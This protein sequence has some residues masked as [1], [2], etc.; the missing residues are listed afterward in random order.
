MNPILPKEYYIPDVEAR[1]WDDGKVYLYGSNDICGADFYCSPI[2]RVFS[3]GDM[4]EW[5]A[6]EV[7]F[8]GY[9]K[10]DNRAVVPGILYAPD[11]ICIDGEYCLFYC[12]ENGGEGMAVS[13]SPT[14]PFTG[15]RVLEYADMTQIDPAVFQDE[16]GT[17]YYYWGQ[18]SAQAG[19]LNKE[20]TGLV[21]ESIV[22]GILTEEE[23]GFHEGISVRK[24][25]GIY[26]VIYTDISRG[27]ATC[28]GYATGTSPLGPFK[29]QGII[30]DNTGCD[31]STWNNHGSIAE[32]DGRWYV[33]YHRST[34]NSRFSRRVCI[35]PIDFDANGRIKE[36]EMTTQGA[37]EPMDT[38]QSM[39][40]SNACLLWGK[41]Y[42]D[43]DENKNEFLG[44]MEDGDW[45]CYK[46][47]DFQGDENEIIMEAA[48]RGLSEVR[49]YADTVHGECIGRIMFDSD[50][51]GQRV[52]VKGL[53]QKNV[54]GIHALYMEFKGEGEDFLH[55]WNFKFN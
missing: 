42:I 51:V 41:V 2:Y 14:G 23:H 8:T 30:I 15:S 29:K 9:E 16:D 37:G 19:I 12:Q 33:F 44:H 31:P 27:N 28:I 36:V 45:V 7:A 3:S 40:A 35:E 54:K 46:Y 18:M 4:K 24:R 52:K 53:V 49:L 1:Q 13:D 55:I 38:R 5:T 22:K 20:K 10:G 11:C 25:N 47:Y 43:T 48:V 39:A 26:Y 17:V 32:V 50:T 6:H 21:K 34:H